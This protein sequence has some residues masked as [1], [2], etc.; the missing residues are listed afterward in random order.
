MPINSISCQLVAQGKTGEN[1]NFPAII[2]EKLRKSAVLRTPSDARSN[3]AKE[4]GPDRIVNLDGRLNAD[5]NAYRKGARYRLMDFA[6]W[7]PAIYAEQQMP[8]VRK[9]RGI[10]ADPAIVQY[11]AALGCLVVR[12]K[13]NAFFSQRKN[14]VA[15]GSHFLGPP[16]DTPDGAD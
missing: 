6:G 1:G 15:P 2:E 9:G 13:A 12:L 10:I 3:T 14:L 5:L 11:G 7:R 8:S 4:G 16:G